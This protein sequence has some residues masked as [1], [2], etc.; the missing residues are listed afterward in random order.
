VPELDSQ[1]RLLLFI[2]IDSI[3][4]RLFGFQCIS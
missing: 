1:G 3:L 4:K 2:G